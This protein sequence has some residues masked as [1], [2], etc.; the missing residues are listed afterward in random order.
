MYAIR[1]A[2]RAS[3]DLLRSELSVLGHSVVIVG[4]QSVA[5]VHVHLHEPGAAVEAGLGLG[6]LSQIRITALQAPAQGERTVLSLVAG[7]GLATAV[8]ELGGV[9]VHAQGGQLTV[10]ELT[11]ALARSSGDAVILPNDMESLEIARHLAAQVR[12]DGRRVAVIPTVAQVQGL[13]ALAVHEPT[14]DFDSAVVAMS[15]A[16]AHTRQGAV[17]IAE[18]A[19]MTM[20]GRCRPGDV[21]GVV[22]GDFVEIGSSVPDVAHRVIQRLLAVGGELV[23]LVLGA[24]AEPG[25]AAELERRTLAAGHRVDVES[26]VGGQSRYV[27]L[28]GVE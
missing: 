18:S 19:A 1:G 12:A 23:T 8:G 14:A 28:V 20:A 22:E 27:L 11:V 21:L 7:D 2:P 16:A 15:T 13:A 17:T 6:T 26:L 9:P 25:L 3:L 4:D 24:D 5:Q 10:Q